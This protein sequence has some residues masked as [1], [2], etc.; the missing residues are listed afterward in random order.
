MKLYKL[1]PIE[2]LDTKNDPWEPWYDCTF[3]FVIRAENEQAAREIANGDMGSES[4]RSDS[5][6][7][8]WLN[9]RYSTCTEL[10]MEGEP[11]IIME[12]Q[13]WA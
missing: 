12:D 13:H 10:E 4:Y 9:P 2:G 7:N 11:Q 6:P 8:P 1:R 3:G 5:E